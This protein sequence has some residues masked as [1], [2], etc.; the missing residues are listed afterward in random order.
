MASEAWPW[1]VLQKPQQKGGRHA[2]KA[3][4]MIV[5]V[6]W[7]EAVMQSKAQRSERRK[8]GK[9][10]TA[11]G[12]DWKQWAAGKG[13]Q[14]WFRKDNFII[15]ILTGIL[16]IIIALPT[17]EE[18]EGEE[19]GAGSGMGSS[20][21]LFGEEQEGQDS[22]GEPGAQTDSDADLDLLYA[23]RLEE[24][25]T[26]ALNQTAGVG[27]VQVM[28]TLKASRELVVEK[29]QPVRHSTTHESDSL[30]GDRTVS[31]VDS[32]EN[33]VY[34]TDGSLSEPYVV[35]TLPP[36]IEGILVVAEGAGS[37]TVNRTIVEI[38]QALFDIE[39][40]KVKVVPRK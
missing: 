39:A 2:E 3:R 29:E 19:G 26:Q 12:R 40:H 38:V 28:I 31:E 8:K 18:K 32:D 24:R 36:Q 17:K 27:E 30:G 13:L 11:M 16:L 37:G 5:P 15:L 9:G 34:R 22:A 4:W 23:A 10:M 20:M 14:K 33:T 7:E 6:T 1:P 21:E 35:K 25:L